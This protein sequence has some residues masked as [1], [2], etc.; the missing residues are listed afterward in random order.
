ML[1]K[2]VYKPYCADFLWTVSVTIEVGKMD[3]FSMIVIKQNSIVF[4]STMTL[5]AVDS[6]TWN[7]HKPLDNVGGATN[8]SHVAAAIEEANTRSPRNVTGEIDLAQL[9]RLL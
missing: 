7:W 2:V 6:L 1:Q 5:N 9:S 3:R 8:V 4:G